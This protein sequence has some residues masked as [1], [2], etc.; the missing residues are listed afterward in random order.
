MDWHKPAPAK[1][2]ESMCPAHHLDCGC[3]L[4]FSGQCVNG[5]QDR[6]LL[7]RLYWCSSTQQRPAAPMAVVSTA[8]DGWEQLSGCCMHCGCCCWHGCMA[9]AVHRG[10]SCSWL[11]TAG[12]NTQHCQTPQPPSCLLSASSFTKWL[13]AACLCSPPSPLP[14]SYLHC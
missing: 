13:H 9:A 4:H 8:G 5:Q 2:S 14:C 10:C 7:A 11:A 3:L 1:Q 12:R 6:A